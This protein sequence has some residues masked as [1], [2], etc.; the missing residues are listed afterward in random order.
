MSY[1]SDSHFA[2]CQQMYDQQEPPDNDCPECPF[3]EDGDFIEIEPGM[4]GCECGAIHIESIA[5]KR[6]SSKDAEIAAQICAEYRIEAKGE[7]ALTAYWNM[8]NW[9]EA[10]EDL[11]E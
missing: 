11:E 6:T 1:H 3:C 7:Y 10:I 2:H 9:L 5:N 8:N 4:W